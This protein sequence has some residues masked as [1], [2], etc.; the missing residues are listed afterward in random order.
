MSAKKETAPLTA[1]PA[2]KSAEDTTDPPKASDLE[3][4]PVAAAFPMLADDEL[5][6]LA[7]DIAANG[8][9][10]PIVIQGGVLI[11]GRNRLRAC[12]LA[13]VEP[14]AVELAADVDPVAFI[15]SANLA[16]RHMSK[17]QQAL[18][19]ARVEIAAGGWDHGHKSELSSDFGISTRYMAM[20]RT[21]IDRDLVVGRHA[22][23]ADAIAQGDLS[24][25]KAY[26]LIVIDQSRAFDPAYVFEV[27]ERTF[28][29]IK[30]AIFLV[31]EAAPEPPTSR[32][33]IKGRELPE[34]EASIKNGL[35]SIGD[36]IVE[37]ALMVKSAQ[38]QNAG[39]PT[40][41]PQLVDAIASFNDIAAHMVANA[42]VA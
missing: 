29:Q 42:K 33:P 31:P 5:Q 14:T 20:A 13:G 10:Q 1:G 19:L 26:D 27:A 16:R 3:V 9:R 11:D 30:W 22:Y 4:H 8:L 39:D 24:L 12:E 38:E 18:A 7:G 41:V 37:K 17:G 35:K 21:V 28:D 2:Q 40:M 15:L 34:L 32:E 25:R 6:A 23:Y 36:L